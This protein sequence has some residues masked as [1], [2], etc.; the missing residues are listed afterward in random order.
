[1]SGKKTSLLRNLEKEMVASGKKEEFEKAIELRD[2]IEKIKRVFENAKIIQ[3]TRYLPFKKMPYR[4]EGYD[5]ANIQGKYAVG[6][7]VVFEDGKPNKNEYRL[8]KI[9]SKGTPD[10]VFMLKEV[11]TRR[12]NHP[13]WSLPDLILVDGGRAQ[14][15][16]AKNAIYGSSTSIYPQIVAL[17]KNEKHRGSKVFVAV[18][19]YLLPL[20]KL[21]AAVKNLFLH[22]DSEAHRF[23]ISYY[24]KLHGR[25]L[26]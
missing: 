17:A 9:R 24:R 19:K 21:P 3:D 26:R 4:I 2:K 23:A 25:S 12:F 15:N 8:F 6:A 11:L 16:T 22:I 18:K 5:V 1:M 7:M 20:S 10:D 14:L 13:E